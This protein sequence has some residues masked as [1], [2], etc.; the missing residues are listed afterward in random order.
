MRLE[1]ALLRFHVL[2]AKPNILMWA[3]NLRRVQHIQDQYTEMVPLLA[4]LVKAYPTLI[5]E[6]HVSRDSYLWAVQVQFVFFEYP[7]M[8]SCP[9]L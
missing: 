2:K 8:L 5:K 3:Y 7:A 4:S 6:E 9:D 1:A